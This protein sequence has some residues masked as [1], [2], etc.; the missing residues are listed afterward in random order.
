MLIVDDNRADVLLIRKA[1]AMVSLSIDLHVVRD[2]HAATRF[3]DAADADE[4]APRPCL[5][6]LDLNLPKKNGEAV[7][8]HLRGSANCRHALVLIVTSSDAIHERKALAL[9]GV[10][11]YFHKPTEYAEFMKLGPVVEKL[12]A[13]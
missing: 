3:F 7:L 11:G 10:S 6:L 12:L 13:A 1:I 9:L 8:K 4:Q 2:G 5:V